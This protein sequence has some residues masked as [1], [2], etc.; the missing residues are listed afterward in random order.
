M[1]KK[2]SFAV[3]KMCENVPYFKH[4]QSKLATSVI[5]PSNNFLPEIELNF[6]RCHCLSPAAIGLTD[7]LSPAAIGP[8][9]VT[10]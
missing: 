9:D 2:I 4:I 10:T 6:D 8:A 7:N 3:S 5:V 1:G